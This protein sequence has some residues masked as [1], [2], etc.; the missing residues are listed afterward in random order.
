MQ[1]NEMDMS[2]WKLRFSQRERSR[3]QNTAC[4]TLREEQ[5]TLVSS[6]DRNYGLQVSLLRG[7]WK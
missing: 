4:S 1:G 6:R 3:H 2:T 5:T 7:V